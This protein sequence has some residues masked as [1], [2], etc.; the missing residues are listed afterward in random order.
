MARKTDGKAKPAELQRFSRALNKTRM[1]AIMAALGLVFLVA[2]RLFLPPAWVQT[3]LMV[4]V[5]GVASSL[6]SVGGTYVGNCPYCGTTTPYANA[7]G[8]RRTKCPRCAKPIA[9]HRTKEGYFFRRV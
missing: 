7:F 2:A 9:V 4:F 3:A 6:L 1:A 5:V 8:V